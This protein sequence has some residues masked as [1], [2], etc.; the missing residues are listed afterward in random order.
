MIAKLNK[1]LSIESI[2]FQ[3]DSFPDD[4]TNIVEKIRRIIEKHRLIHDS[5]I[6]KSPYKKE[7]VDL[8]GKR[9]GI[10]IHKFVTS[11]PFIPAA[12]DL[13]SGYDKSRHIFYNSN[14]GRD[15]LGDDFDDLRKDKIKDH[16]DTLIVKKGTIDLK[17]AKVSGMFSDNKFTLYINFGMLIQIGLT[18]Q[19]IS[20]VILHELGHAFTCCEYSDRMSR[21]NQVL[22]NISKEFT[23]TKEPK[24]AYIYKELKKLDP[25]VTKEVADDLVEGKRLLVGYKLY[26]L[27]DFSP[28]RSDN[29][30]GNAYSQTS[31]EQLADQFAAR[32]GYGKHLSTGLEKFHKDHTF[33]GF[34]SN[35]TARHIFLYMIEISQ[36]LNFVIAIFALFTPLFVIA[37]YYLAIIGIIIFSFNKKHSHWTYDD[38]KERYTRIRNELTGNLKDQELSNNEIKELLSKISII[39]GV[40]ENSFN[41]KW[42]IHAI[43]DKV[44]SGNRKAITR[45][46]QEQLLEKLV[47]ND[48]YIKAA[49]FKVLNT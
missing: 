6:N 32:F 36:T 27:M 41:H 5:K 47:N 21:N 34:I 42:F 26:N 33:A 15:S 23:G 2:N 49:E 43:M 24:S 8:I 9:L 39:D 20:A 38:I 48:L 25:K 40:V 16:L 37:A 1:S 35:R 30:V 17:K 4:I 46:E 28:A 29:D 19:E 11:N 7:L 12:V 44:L 18:D 13:S 14:D 22:S 10:T 31:C 45:S 3:K